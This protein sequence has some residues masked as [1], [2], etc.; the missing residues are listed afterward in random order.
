M[1]LSQTIWL[2]AIALT[3]C[4]AKPHVTWEQLGNR[5]DNSYVQRITVKNSKD[6]DRLCFN[7]FARKMTPVNPADSIHEIVPG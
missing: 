7:Q 2:L 3:A 1:K 6:I 4:S 5:D